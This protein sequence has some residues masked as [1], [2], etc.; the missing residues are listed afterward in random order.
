[1]ITLNERVKMFLF[2][3]WMSTCYAD[4]HIDDN[5]NHQSS[6]KYTQKD[7]MSVLN[8]ES[9]YWWQEQL[10]HF[11]DVVYPNYVENGTVKDS[12]EFLSGKK[13]NKD[14]VI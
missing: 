7:G 4:E 5:M 10:N 8:R 11:N 12:K 9:G 2:A 14:L 1:M 6:F 13:T 3:R